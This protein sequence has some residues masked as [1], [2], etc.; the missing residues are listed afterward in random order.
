MTANARPYVEARAQ[1]GLWASSRFLLLRRFSQLFFL[2]L[3]L[4]GPLFGIWIAK[5][6]L[7]SSMTLGVLPLN[8]PFIFLQSLAA[9]HWPE[10][11]AVLGTAIVLGSYLLFGGR[12]YCASA[13][14][15]WPPQIGRSLGA[16]A[17]ME[18]W[19]SQS[20]IPP[21]PSSAR[22]PTSRTAETGRKGFSV[23]LM[24]RGRRP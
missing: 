8:D 24:Q 10:G 6:T 19:G 11:V 5:G 15:V 13:H 18:R 14:L 16:V 21:G 23:A 2:A 22:A 20:V 12:S 7:A 3:F 9:R 4:S 1:K 17:G